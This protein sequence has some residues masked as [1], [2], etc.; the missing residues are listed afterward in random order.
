ME[1]NPQIK[2]FII[3]IIIGFVLTGIPFRITK[4]VFF[5]A[6]INTTVNQSPIIIY[7]TIEKIVTVTP[8]IDGKIYFADEYQNGTR[9]LNH[10]FS[11]F[12][13]DINFKNNNLKV[14][15]NVY[16]YRIFPSYHYHDLDNTNAIN[17]EYLTINPIDSN[18]EFLFLMVDISEDE[19]ISSKTN[20]IWLINE[21]SFAIQIENILY[22]PIIYPKQREILELENTANNQNSE[23]IQAFGQTRFYN[24]NA[25][26]SNELNNNGTP[27]DNS[28]VGYG[29]ITSQQ[30]YYLYKGLSNA[31]DGYILFE[32]PK[33]T[34][35]QDIKILGNFG[36]FGNSQWVIKNV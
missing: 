8:T 5:P 24:P 11:F 16:G 4:D 17:Q 31:E 36:S 30:H 22:T 35:Y 10:P 27:V 3:I 9:I 15:I 14:S 33:N 20:D 26:S 34:N 12:R 19:I 13:N 32:I 18:N 2:I 7:K 29:G 28:F 25:I 6:K 21:N 1:L 23:Y